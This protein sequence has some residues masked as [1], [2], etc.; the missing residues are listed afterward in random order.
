M[1][2]RCLSLVACVFL[3]A[4]GDPTES[5]SVVSSS[6]SGV[7]GAG[8][9]MGS[10]GGSG[11]G[12]GTPDPYGVVWKPFK[13]GAGGWLVGMDIAQDGTIVVRT[14]TYG[15][16]LWNGSSWQQLVT[17]ASMPASYSDPSTLG[18]AEGVYE[19]RIAPSST[20]RFYMMYN[21]GVLRSDDKGS[22]WT[23]T[24]FAKV[25]ANPN[26]NYRTVGQKM[27]VD[28]IQPD[29]VY[30]GT[31]QNGL[32]M[33]SDGGVS[34]SQVSDVPVSTMVNGE[35]P[36]IA[37]I[38][39]DGA[40]GQIYA[41]SFG[42]GVYRSTNA[43]LTWAH[44]SGG[45]TD[46][47]DGKIA[48]DGTYYAAGDDYSKVWRY[49]S[50]G[51][52]DITPN[53]DGWGGVITDPFNANRVLAIRQGGYLNMS[54][55]RGATWTGT[56]WT[57]NRVAT[58]IPWLA[59]TEGDFMSEGE[60]IFDPLVPDKLW[61]SEG[62][63]VWTTD[64]APN[65]TWTTPTAWTSTSLGIEQ[66]VANDVLSPPGGKPLTIQWDR[67]V[68]H[69]ADPDVFPS[70]HGPDN[71]NAIIAGWSI[72]YASTNPSY[73]AGVFSFFGERSA[74]SNDGGQTWTQF[75]SKP[76]PA[77]NGSLGGC[78]AVS[79]PSNMVWIVSNNNNPY[80]TQDGGQSWT[81]IAMPGAPTTGETGW[82]W[83][84]YLD[85]QIVAADRVNEG[86]FYAYNYLTGVYRST[87]GGSTWS[88][89]KSGEINP[90]SG[91]NAK[92]RSVPENAGHLYFTAGALGSGGDPQPDRTDL[93]WRS[94]DG[95]TT[96]TSL[97]NVVEVY[98]FNFGQS[99]V[100]GGYPAIYIAGWAMQNDVYQYGIFRS[101][102]EGQTWKQIGKFPLNSLDFVKSV[103]GD[104]N[105]Y[106]RVY[107]GFSGSGFAYA[108]TD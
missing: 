89:V 1:S 84:Y 54:N 96:W 87:D 20:S 81:P 104:M 77:V 69:H 60:M 27:A 58:D 16:Y 59:W 26:D 43:G 102:D 37:G 12:G 76:P 55:D 82:G 8:G 17:A 80:L 38:A 36:G 93:F 78:I 105:I 91:Y 7:G 56:M 42:H 67:P 24:A 63:G 85:R 13:T 28:P 97:P 90:W 74:Y 4:C 50:N 101:D 75:A 66:L 64:I 45:P 68:F 99:A 39:V 40:S 51:W 106:G 62:T 30:V 29:V 35:Y 94:T 23:Q 95:G 57:H 22:T 15:A 21:G 103:S 33:T 53:P 32:W 52:S 19:I 100:P 6:A 5:E 18:T 31:P 49:D 92:L 70:E 41:S 98:D 2:P 107:V 86:T 34:W 71:E 108:D 73:V 48:I 25:P 83:A 14:D 47:C 3:V 44:L 88:L 11:E 10:T 61:F 72:D 65:A 9:T 46:T 79:T